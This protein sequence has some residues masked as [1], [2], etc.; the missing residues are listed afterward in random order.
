M[1]AEGLGKFCPVD[2]QLDV[3]FGDHEPLVALQPEDAAIMPGSAVTFFAG[4]LSY[5]PM[6]IQWLKDGAELSGATNRVLELSAV[7]ASDQGRYSVLFSNA[8]GSVIS[9][10][11]LLLVEPRLRPGGLDPTFQLDN[12]IPRL[13]GEPHQAVQDADGNWIVAFTLDHRPLSLPAYAGY[14]GGYGPNC[15][16]M[17]LRLTSQGKEDPT[18]ARF[19]STGAAYA[20]AVDSSGRVYVGSGNKRELPGITRLR[21]DGS[22]DPDFRVS[23]D[24]TG[25]S[26]E[27]GAWVNAILVDSSDRVLIG[28]R[29]SEVN[30]K[31]RWGLARM[32]LS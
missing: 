12:S 16:L 23:I 20:L 32:A 26:P 28:G 3:V 4:A 19:N 9:R 6:A 21:V 2:L 15:G 5:S 30:G 31:Q 29:F 8:K 24:W 18:F 11:A 14:S 27:Y 22:R 13:L 10:E 17:V 7:D 25:R 1:L